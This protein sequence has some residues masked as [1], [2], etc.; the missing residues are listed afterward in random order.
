MGRGGVVRCPG[1]R[2][3]VSEWAARCPSCDSDLAGAIVVEDWD[4]ALS[5]SRRRVDGPNGLQRRSVRIGAGIA[6]LAATVAIVLV[7]GRAARHHPLSDHQ[8]ICA[9]PTATW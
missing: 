6:L 9:A 1:C 8:V 7:A 2:M 5:R 3:A 4:A